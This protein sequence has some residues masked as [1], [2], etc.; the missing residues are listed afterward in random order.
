[1]GKI[2]PVHVGIAPFTDTAKLDIQC[3]NA[4]EPSE[5]YE[6]AA[7]SFSMRKFKEEDNLDSMTHHQS[8]R[9]EVKTFQAP[10]DVA[11]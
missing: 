4:I 3:S 10:S 6:P 1:M 9:R 8:D 11:G 2:A 5:K 7:S